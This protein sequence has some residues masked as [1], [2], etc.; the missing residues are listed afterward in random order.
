MQPFHDGV[1]NTGFITFRLVLAQA[2]NFSTYG[3]F[4]NISLTFIHC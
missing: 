4:V 2:F 3:I 1:S